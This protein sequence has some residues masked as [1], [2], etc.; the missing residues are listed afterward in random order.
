MSKSPLEL[1]D[2]C[3]FGGIIQVLN[4]QYGSQLDEYYLL[5]AVMVSV[6]QQ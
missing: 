3:M 4:I 5:W 6:A 1:K 2:A